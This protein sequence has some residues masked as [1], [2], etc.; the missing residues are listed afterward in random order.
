MDRER[1][2][3]RVVRRRGNRKPCC[4]E[5]SVAVTTICLAFVWDYFFLPTLLF[6]PPLFLSSYPSYSPLCCFYINTNLQSV[7]FN[8]L[9][10]K[11][12]GLSRWAHPLYVYILVHAHSNADLIPKKR[13]ACTFRAGVLKCCSDALC[14]Q[15]HMKHFLLLS[16]GGVFL[17]AAISEFWRKV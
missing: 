14:Q 12:H 8:L 17:V 16:S 13:S 6:S 3:K 9:K 1:D 15:V 4:W 7:V 2:R 11:N 5:R 10:W